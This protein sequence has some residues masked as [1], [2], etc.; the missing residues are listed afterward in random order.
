MFNRYTE[1]S[2]S[3]PGC[4]TLCNGLCIGS[5]TSSATSGGCALIRSGS[6]PSGS[7]ADSVTYGPTMSVRWQITPVGSPAQLNI[8]AQHAGHGYWRVDCLTGQDLE[9]YACESSAVHRGAQHDNDTDLKNIWMRLGHVIASRRG[10]FPLPPSP[11]ET[12]AAD[13]DCCFL[14]GFRR[15]PIPLLGG[16]QQPKSGQRWRC[17]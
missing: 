8:R 13:A 9:F 2:L 16:C 7:T 10:R 11:T 3:A 12:R 17:E 4:P 6:P 1:P 5:G 14:N 15:R